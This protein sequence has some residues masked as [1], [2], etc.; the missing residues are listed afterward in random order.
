[1]A[2]GSK[3]GARAALEIC[4]DRAQFLDA[5][6]LAPAHIGALSIN[7]RGREQGAER[8][9]HAGIGR[10]DD[11]PDAENLGHFGPV[12]RASSPECHQDEVARIDAALDRQHADRVRH[13]LIGDRDDRQCRLV[14]AGAQ[15]LGQQ[16]ECAEGRRRIEF[17]GATEQ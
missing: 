14:H 2:L 7:P 5:D 8:R 12:H 9:G 3:I 11:L 17:Y 6:I 15:S 10:H 16:L 1:V 4:Q 13:V